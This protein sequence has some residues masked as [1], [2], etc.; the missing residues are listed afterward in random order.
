MSYADIL[1]L[2]L[3]FYLNLYFGFTH[4]KSRVHFDPSPKKYKYYSLIWHRV[5]TLY[6]YIVSQTVHSIY[7]TQNLP[8][9][10]YSTSG[11]SSYISTRLLWNNPTRICWVT[12]Q[13]YHING[14]VQEGHN[15]IANTL[16]LRLSCN[17]PLGLVQEGRNSIANAPELCLSCTNPLISH[18]ICT[19]FSGALFCSGHTTSS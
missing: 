18:G 5:N 9:A 2:K 16:E 14:L 15:S 13:I 10:C 12:W 6:H 3:Q 1:V 8:N 4:I 19:W 11:I 7:C 17:N